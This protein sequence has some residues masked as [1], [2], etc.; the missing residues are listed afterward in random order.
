MAVGAPAARRRYDVA[1]RL[2]LQ[3]MYG[4]VAGFSPTVGDGAAVYQNASSL[5]H[6]LVRLV[7]LFDTLCILCF[8]SSCAGQAEMWRG[9]HDHVHIVDGAM[10]DTLLPEGIKGHHG[11]GPS[12]S[13]TECAVRARAGRRAP[14]PRPSNNSLQGVNLR[15]NLGTAVKQSL[16]RSELSISVTAQVRTF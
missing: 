3:R 10:T 11:A 1:C 15:L 7:R 13:H 12:V 2:L 5:P 4:A 14:R 8:K 6:A 9:S 16:P